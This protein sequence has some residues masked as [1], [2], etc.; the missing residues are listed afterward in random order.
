MQKNLLS[1]LLVQLKPLEARWVVPQKPAPGRAAG[2]HRP[3]KPSFPSCTPNHHAQ[4][5][6]AQ[7]AV[8]CWFQHDKP[9][10]LQ[11]L[12][13]IPLQAL[14]ANNMHAQ[15]LPLDQLH[16]SISSALFWL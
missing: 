15:Y 2:V 13:A 14:D 1:L 4:L 8:P 12:H 16:A 6:L 10:S 11:G 3:L 9:V 7:T 5:Y